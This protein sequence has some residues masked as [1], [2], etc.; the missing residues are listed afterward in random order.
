MFGTLRTI[1]FFHHDDLPGTS[2][3]AVDGLF[4]IGAQSRYIFNES[5]WKDVIGRLQGF[6]V[7]D[8]SLSLLGRKV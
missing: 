4:P 7:F 5:V 1:L 2:F 8:H 3:H 6:Q